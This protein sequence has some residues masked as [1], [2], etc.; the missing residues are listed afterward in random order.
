MEYGDLI[1]T[2]NNLNNLRHV[3]YNDEGHECNNKFF[4]QEVVDLISKKVSELTYGLDELNR[5]IVVSDQ[6]II[7]VMDS[8]YNNFTPETGDIFGRYNVIGIN[9]ESD[10]SRMIDRVIQIIVSTLRNEKEMEQNNKKLSVWTTVLGDFNE[11]GLQSHPQIKLRN[12]HIPLM[13]MEPRF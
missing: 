3:G 6:G 12:N 11:H 7:E 4:S 13:Q 8:V 9:L 2:N 10:I 1:E 5:K